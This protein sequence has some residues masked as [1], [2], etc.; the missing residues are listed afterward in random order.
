MEVSPVDVEDVDVASVVTVVEVCSVVVASVVTTVEVCPVVVA[1]VVTSAWIQRKV[2]RVEPGVRLFDASQTSP[3][4]HCPTPKQ[5]PPTG[6]P[7][8]ST[9]QRQLSTSEQYLLPGHPK[10]PATDILI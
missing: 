6:L 8:V 9:K 1:P 10:P 3:E 4:A 5:H 7:P 2:P